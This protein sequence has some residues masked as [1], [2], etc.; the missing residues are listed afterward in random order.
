MSVKSPT[1]DMNALIFPG[2]K[3]CGLIQEQFAAK[4]G[5][6]VVTLNLGKLSD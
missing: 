3:L 5:V 2:R 4:V 6:T 1:I